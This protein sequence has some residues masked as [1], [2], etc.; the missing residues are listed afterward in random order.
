L[1][2]LVTWFGAA[3]NRSPKVTLLRLG[4]SERRGYRARAAHQPGHSGGVR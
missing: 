1:P 4:A 3:P 2:A